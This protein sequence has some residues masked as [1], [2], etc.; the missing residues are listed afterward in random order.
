[1]CQNMAKTYFDC[2]F[3][4]YVEIISINGGLRQSYGCNPASFNLFLTSVILSGSNPCS[5]MLLTK[6]AN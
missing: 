4:V 1:M 3:A 2:C 5:M 6:A